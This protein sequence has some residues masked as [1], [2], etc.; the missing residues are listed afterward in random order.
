MTK[1]SQRRSS[2]KRLI[3]KSLIETL[4]LLSI[5]GLLKGVREAKEDIK[6]GRTKLFKQRLRGKA[7]G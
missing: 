3:H 7:G 6:A 2:K 1:H 5:P 4:K